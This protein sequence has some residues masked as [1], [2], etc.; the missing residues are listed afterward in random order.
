MSQVGPPN[1]PPCRPVTPS[2]PALGPALVL[3]TRGCPTAPTAAPS[4]VNSAGSELLDS[5]TNAHGCSHPSRTGTSTTQRH[6]PVLPVFRTGPASV[7]PWI[8]S[9]LSSLF[10]DKRIQGIQAGKA[11]PSAVSHTQPG[12][13]A[14]STQLP[15]LPG[16]LVTHSP[17]APL[18]P[19]AQGWRV[20]A[21]PL[22]ERSQRLL[23]G[24][25]RG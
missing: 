17:R 7:S 12:D 16:V 9:S 11:A 20:A 18:L 21:R 22:D 14:T 24:A 25:W 15:L 2:G 13:R 23:Q 5:P 1:S 8:P 10:L 19:R 3:A 4:A 6:H